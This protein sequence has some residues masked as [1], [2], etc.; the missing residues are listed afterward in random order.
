MCKISI[1]QYRFWY[2]KSTNELYGVGSN[3]TIM[4]IIEVISRKSQILTLV[5]LFLVFFYFSALIW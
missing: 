1:I 4:I 3:G 2:Q 5:F